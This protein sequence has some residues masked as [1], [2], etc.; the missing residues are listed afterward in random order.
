MS[1][2][3]WTLDADFGRFFPRPRVSRRTH[4]FGEFIWWTHN[5]IETSWESLLFSSLFP[6]INLRNWAE[7]KRNPPCIPTEG[8]QNKKPYF[9]FLSSSPKDVFEWKVMLRV[10]NIGYFWKYRTLSS[11][12]HYKMSWTEVS[13]MFH[14]IVID[15]SFKI[16]G[17]WC[18]WIELN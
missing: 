2:Q 18:L 1:G 12:N 5:E 4:A 14:T 17:S 16:C 13:R 15:G 11:W 9:I 3:Q 10:N 7:K 8:S 6:V